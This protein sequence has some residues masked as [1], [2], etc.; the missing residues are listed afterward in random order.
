VP[1]DCPA[2]LIGAHGPT[3]ALP[4]GSTGKTASRIAVRLEPAGY[5]QHTT[6]RKG[7]IEYQASGLEPM[8]A[9]KSGRM[10]Y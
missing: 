9:P 4:I 7:Q 1:I 3:E 10:P 6:L 2:N 8:T 5:A